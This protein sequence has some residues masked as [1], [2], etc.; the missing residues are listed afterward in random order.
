M[1]RNKEF[2]RMFMVYVIAVKKVEF[3]LPD[4]EETTPKQ[5]EEFIPPEFTELLKPM[6]VRDGTQVELR[7]TFLGKPQPRIIWYHNGQ[8]IKP[9]PDFQII[10]DYSKRES[11]LIIVEV[12]PEDEGEYTC[13]ARNTYGESITSCRLAVVGEFIWF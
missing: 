11:V 8:E 2:I 6:N 12:F 4:E 10:I 5:P 1:L 13:T 9:S 3:V 7:V